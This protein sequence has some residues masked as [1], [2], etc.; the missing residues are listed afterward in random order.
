MNGRMLGA[1]A[2]VAVAALT[3]P[4]WAGK[5]DNSL[6]FADPQVLENVDP[7]FNSVRIGVIVGQHI[8]D[9]LIY[10]D[11]ETDEYKGLLATSWKWIDDK[12]IELELRKGVK[13][14]NG[15]T[16][17]AD[18][19]VYTLNFVSK[20]ENKVVTQQN[21]SWIDHA[22]KLDDYKVRI[23]TKRPFPAA[24]EYL[25]GPVVIHPHEYYAQV[26]PKGMSEKPVGTG[27]YRLVENAMGKY[28]RLERNPDYFK[29]SPKGQPKIEKLEFRFIPD[30]QTR[31]AEVLSGGVDLARQLTADQIEQLRA[32]P[33][34]QVVSGEIMRFVFLQLNSTENTPSPPL[35]DVRVRKAI[36]HAIN[37][38]GMVK[39]IV[40]EGSRVINVMCF[41]SQFGC[42]DEGA[43]RY[44][45]DP[46]KAKAL[47]AEAGYPNGFE[48]DLYGFQDRNQTEAMVAFL[49]AVGIRANLRWSQYAAVR[50]AM[51]SG[52]AP[53]SHQSWGSFSVNDV[54]ASTP[55]FFKFTPDDVTRD[56][57]VRDLLERGDTSIDPKVR[58]EAYGKALR[59]IAEQAYAIPLYTLPALYAANKD[60]VF[61]AYRDEIPRVWEM[62]YK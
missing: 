6:H 18:D 41:P 52:K 34:V 7:Y 28:L 62:S 14:H 44:P 40:G 45:Y 42:S 20:P 58:K 38:E 61:K 54:S 49:G 11:P 60:L 43:P 53:L 29:D 36:L 26:G 23:V 13:F 25:A 1:A 47:L 5:K 48:I 35:R 9:T 10:R 55:V 31:M 16:F 37:R 12:T 57:E 21:V 39:S 27:P 30:P 4:A 50:E 22:E 3:S 15:A 59:R 17:N 51:R 56:A 8:W 33:N 2:L 32:V 19:V 46:A 24:L